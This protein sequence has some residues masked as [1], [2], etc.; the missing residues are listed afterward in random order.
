MKIFTV[1]LLC[2]VSVCKYSE[3]ICDFGLT[4]CEIIELGNNA[5][6]SQWIDNLMIIILI[7]CFIW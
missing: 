3:N 4:C 6:D 5:F 2:K 1:F 7:N